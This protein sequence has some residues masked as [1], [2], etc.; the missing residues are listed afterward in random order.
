MKFEIIMLGIFLVSFA[1]AIDIYSGESYTFSLNEAYEYYSIVGNS[2][3]VN[4]EIIQDGLNVTI[5]IDKYSLADS[6]QIIFFDKEKEIIIEHHYSGGGGGGTRTIYKDRNITVTETITEY[7]NKTIECEDCIVPEEKESSIINWV[8]SIILTAIFL[9]LSW[10]IWTK[11][12][13]IN[14]P[15]EG[16]LLR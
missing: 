15:Q 1:S 4:L 8:T 5:T 11:K 10:K 6:Y 7:I 14:N 12:P 9:F 13:K 16:V 2:S 3:P